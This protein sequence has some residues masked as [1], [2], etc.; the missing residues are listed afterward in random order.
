M[1]KNKKK[2]K[3]DDEDD[4]PRVGDQ[5]EYDLSL[6]KKDLAKPAEE[7][8]DVDF[9]LLTPS[10]DAAPE[11]TI[12]A[13]LDDFPEVADDVRRVGDAT[14]ATY[15]D[16]DLGDVPTASASASSS[17]LFGTGIPQAAA[18]ESGINLEPIAP[19]APASGWFDSVEEAAGPATIPTD[20]I[21]ALLAQ[22][23]TGELDDASDIF[24]GPVP[25]ALPKSDVSDVIAAT[26]YGVARP[27]DGE[28]AKPASRAS[29]VAL[30]FGRPSG[31]SSV[32]KS[33]RAEDKPDSLFGDE[34]A[35]SRLSANDDADLGSLPSGGIDASSILADLSEPGSMPG[36][37]SAIRLETPGHEATLR[38]ESDP[39][40]FTRDSTD[41]DLTDAEDATDWREQS[42]SDLLGTKP[43]FELTPDAGKVDP[44]ADELLAEDPSLSTAPSS[45]F[46]G[47][48]PPKGSGSA[49]TGSVPVA[50]PESSADS[51]EFSDHPDPNTAD[52]G[53]FH[54]LPAGAPGAVDFDIPESDE[55]HPER[56][57]RAAIPEDDDDWTNAKTD[58]GPGASGILSRKKKI[59]P[60]DEMAPIPA[61]PVKGKPEKK[62][63]AARVVAWA[64]DATEE[65]AL[66]SKKGRPEPEPTS[67]RGLA[68]LALGLLLGVGASAGA[69]F[70]GVL[71]NKDATPSTSN[72]NSGATDPAL[73]NKYTA[74]MADLTA[75]IE[76]TTKAEKDATDA[77]DRVAKL[78]RDLKLAQTAVT[79]AEKMATAQATI[80]ANLKAMTDT[81][82]AD[83]KTEKE[84]TLAAEKLATTEKEKTLKAEKDLTAEKEKLV[85]LGKDLTAEKE[86]VATLV[87]DVKAE[88]DNTAKV[89]KDLKGMLD[90][91]ATDSKKDLDAAKES[92]TKAMDALTAAN[93]TSTEIAKELVAG[94][95]LPEKHDAKQL[96]AAVRS[97]VSRATGPDLSKLIPAD[98][99]AVAGTGLS[100][101]HVLDLASRTN[102][103]DAAAKAAG[104]EIAKLKDSHAAAMKTAADAHA[105]DL[106]KAADAS[107]IAM[108]KLKT[109]LKT[110]KDGIAAEVK[111]ATDAANV[112]MDK[113]KV[114]LKTAKDGTAAEVKKA[115][116]AANV[117][118]EKLKTDHAAELKKADAAH[119][120]QL[121]SMEGAV[122][123]EKAK[124][125]EAERR[126]KALGGAATLAAQELDRQSA[127]S[128]ARGLD[129]GIAEFKAGRFAAA[130][131]ALEE[132]AKHDPNDA[133]AWYY[134]GATR[135]AQGK[136]DDAKLDFKK[137]AE[138]EALRLVP[139]RQID[140]MI[141]SIQGPARDALNAARP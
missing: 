39:P 2:P 37:S 33:P 112:A 98:L 71:P 103:A 63:E 24:A 75:A 34:P 61:T 40:R 92:L 66:P 116:D 117:A 77:K 141:G 67:K 111:K 91:L 52:S 58:P 68:G 20:A 22:P 96:V 42:G 115:T 60:T 128:A 120:E 134:L 54:V 86:K 69:Y 104:G 35:P 135:W 93:A 130:A 100:T 70:S 74:A 132:A 38:A 18:A 85:T 109:E 129:V 19:V 73:Q 21:D 105:A 102:K 140:A 13:S 43:E 27:V 64:D 72:K 62:S 88:K 12:G 83:L 59:D 8:G 26:A 4:A 78:D 48:K 29:D 110:A 9:D 14:E 122:L 84:K 49:S 118:M 114:E 31:G 107:T 41:V 53:S 125:A 131:T 16:I 79:E 136:S 36:D 44:F 23:A 45:I 126:F 80:A 89:E 6:N 65:P 56:T 32:E 17:N 87:K 95:V 7:P 30:N 81:L 121:K 124:T 94:K 50:N 28:K 5:T 90:K 139:A 133:L 3:I 46:T 127:L 25:S 137:G 113:L 47:G 101:G 1:A 55:P 106:K 82:T 10:A 108:D 138:R 119:A 99:S 97:T 15:D 51:V 57:I 76:K 123:A 11:R